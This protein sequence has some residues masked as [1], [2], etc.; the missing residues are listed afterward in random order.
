LLPGV[1]KYQYEL[2]SSGARHESR[3]GD[4]V[5]EPRRDLD[6]EFVSLL[7][8]VL[9][10]DG[11]EIV[12]IDECQSEAL[13][14]AVQ[15]VETVPCAEKVRFAKNGNDVTTLA[16]ALFDLSMAAVG[17]IDEHEER[18]LACY[19]TDLD[20]LPREDTVCTYAMLED[21]VTV[22]EDTRDD[23]RFADNPNLAAF[24]IRFYASANV[25]TP[26]GK[27]IGSFC[28]FD[29]APRTFDA[30]AREHLRL[31]ADEAMEQLELRRRLHE[32]D[33][34]TDRAPAEPFVGDGSGR[35]E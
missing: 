4:D 30:A 28:A 15:F 5:L 10:V 16:A 32:A 31:F 34:G 26:D 29:D 35:D 17:L 18:F 9:V 33:S 13:P 27:V 2:V 22:V 11:F 3:V 14:L 21:E 20:T 12:E 8:S 23:P 19:G 6:Q 25:R 24:D 7:M 1:R